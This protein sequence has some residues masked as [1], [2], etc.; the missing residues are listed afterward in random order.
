MMSVLDE[1]LGS[2][3]EEPSVSL[4]VSN[5]SV[6]SDDNSLDSDVTTWYQIC[7]DGVVKQAELGHPLVLDHVS[8]P[9]IC[10]VA[11]YVSSGGVG[12]LS[13]PASSGVLPLGYIDLV[14]PKDT[15][16]HTQ[17]LS[18]GRDIYIYP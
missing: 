14:V 15:R 5:M 8:T 12:V 11:L 10:S 18:I 9:C 4:S 7:V 17:D 13:D 2:L 6:D 1:K 16:S 3:Q